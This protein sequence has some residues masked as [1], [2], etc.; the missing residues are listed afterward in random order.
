MA[1]PMSWEE[2]ADIVAWMTPRWPMMAKWEEAVWAP[3]WDDLS[4][5]AAVDVREMIVRLHRSGAEFPPR[6][7]II[8]KM[9]KEFDRL[10]ARALPPPGEKVEADVTWDQ[11]A[12]AEGIP[13]MSLAE[14]ALR[15]VLDVAAEEPVSL[16]L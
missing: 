13:G 1:E 4:P 5:Y 14:Y 15:D 11:F 10:P 12:E 8:L 16:D 3:M 9:L 6:S 2:W 7:G